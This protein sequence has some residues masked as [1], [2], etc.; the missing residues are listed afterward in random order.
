[1]TYFG[2]GGEVS[3]RAHASHPVTITSLI[4][5]EPEPKLKENAGPVPGDPA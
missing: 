3:Q 5:N 1:V 2:K 4:A